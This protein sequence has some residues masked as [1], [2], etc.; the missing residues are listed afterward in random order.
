MPPYC[1]FLLWLSIQ[2]ETFFDDA[3]GLAAKAA[4]IDSVADKK[5]PPVAVKKDTLWATLI[6]DL[7]LTYE[8]D[9]KLRSVY[10]SGDSKAS[11]SERRRL[12]LAVVGR[13]HFLCRLEC[14]ALILS[15][16]RHI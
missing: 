2:D 10:K 1:R 12:A 11:K 15:V 14:W 13:I 7:T 8:Q 16:C 9:E 3:N 6:G 5:K 4:G